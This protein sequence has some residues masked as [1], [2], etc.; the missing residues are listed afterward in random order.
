M[1]FHAVAA[2]FLSGLPLLAASAPVEAEAD[3]PA[4]DYDAIIV[5]GG[6]AGLSALSGLAR[7]RRRTLL[8]DS[9]E[10][11]NDP[12]RHMHDVLGYD[13]L[14]PAYYRWAARGQLSHYPTVTMI[15]GTVTKIEPM[16]NN[17]Y[18]KVTG[19]FLGA[20]GSTKTA[21]K[22]VLATGLRDLLPATPGI[23]EN[24]GK[25]IYWCPWCDGYEHA[26]QRLGLL[27]SLD[28]IP[29]L[30]REMLTLDKDMVAFVNG[31]DTP[32]ARAATEK[33]SPKWQEYLKLHNV[34]V[35]NR[36]IT[37]IE[38]LA[39]GST[40]DE[41]PSLPTNPEH[42]EFSVEFD[43]GEPMVR[44]AF[45]TSFKDEQAS[46]VG[47][48]MGVT[49]YGGR[50]AADATKGLVTNV[51]GVYAIGDANS[52][53]VTNVPHALFSGKR[54]A[55]YLHVQLERETAAKELA[56]VAGDNDSGKRSVDEEARSVW[57]VMN[58]RS[59][60]LLYAGEFDQ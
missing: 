4:T 50:L 40:G 22:I 43:S 5:G 10:Y 19:N 30:V 46:K 1:L 34:T 49:L 2:L 28:Q 59:G 42:D 48:D 13:G 44:D 18:F 37:S 36:I 29:G 41:D 35:E 57:K 23:S 55:V 21:R 8:I 45:L 60:D 32:E 14:T 12:T 39:D 27:A 24:W 31:T 3:G 7:V 11:R 9:G 51:P 54:T 26:D 47:S 25:G 17:E 38:R 6:P 33:K 16:Q 52:D 20:T 56:A 53:N 15:N 58:G